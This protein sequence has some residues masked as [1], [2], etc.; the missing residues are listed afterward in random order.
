MK[1][2][3]CKRKSKE[4]YCSLHKEAYDNIL[5]KYVF[6]KRVKEISWK[7][8]LKELVEIS[9]TGIWAKEVVEY[10]LENKD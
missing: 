1:C 4:K 8:Y 7:Q 3:I 10:L 5:R 2:V 9:Y 6:W